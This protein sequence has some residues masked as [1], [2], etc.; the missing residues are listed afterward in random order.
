MKT[1][2]TAY[3]TCFYI[4]GEV[5]FYDEMTDKIIRSEK[6]NEDDANKLMDEWVANAP[7]DVICEKL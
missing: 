3:C 5:V 7:G 4:D 2:Y 1:R 6:V